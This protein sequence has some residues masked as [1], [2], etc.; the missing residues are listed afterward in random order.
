MNNLKS[1][2]EKFKFGIFSLHTRRFGTLAE[3]MIQLLYKLSDSNSLAFDKKDK[4]NK[5]VEIKFSRVMRKDDERIKVENAISQAKGANIK[6]RMLKLDDKASF[7]CNIQQIKTKE[8]DVLYY[9]LFFDDKV[10]IY[11]VKSEDV[12][13]IPGYSNKQHRGNEGEGQFHIN[14]TNIG[15]HNKYLDKTL[16]YDD[17]Y[18]I[19]S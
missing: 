11:K 13:K 1:E 17:L 5:K 18:E 15:I 9:G 2:I 19:F 14:D 7:D 6:E 12:K 4:K 10:L 8:F 3:L 16:S